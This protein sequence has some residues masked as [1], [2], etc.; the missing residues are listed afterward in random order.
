VHCEPSATECV[1]IAGLE[2]GASSPQ[3]SWSSGH[4]SE[5]GEE[6]ALISYI[7]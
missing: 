4:V 7:L 1:S 6:W 2:A 3:L 5:F